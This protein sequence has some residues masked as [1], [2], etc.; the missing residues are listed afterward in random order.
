M[1]ETTITT[2]ETIA[3]EFCVALTSAHE[4]DLDAP[5][6]NA[7]VHPLAGERIDNRVDAD[8]NGATVEFLW[9]DED[10]ARTQAD[11]MN[12]TRRYNGEPRAYYVVVSR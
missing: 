9:T 2:T 3:P 7:D 4:A 12:A 6:T 1:Y 5:A 10:T 11:E 8:G